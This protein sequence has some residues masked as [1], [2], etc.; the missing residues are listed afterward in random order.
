MTKRERDS[1]IEDL[2]AAISPE[3]LASIKEARDDYKEG[4]TMSHEEI[5]EK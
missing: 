5:F 1:F 2:L 3:Y 4:R